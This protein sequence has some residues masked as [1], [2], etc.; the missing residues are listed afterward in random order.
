MT[1]VP[2]PQQGCLSHIR[3]LDLLGREVRE[4]WSG[5]LARGECLTVSWDGR[6]DERRL[7]HSGYYFL[8][9]RVGGEV[10]MARVVWLR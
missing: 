8:S 5:S 10:T 6:D 3:V 2:A 1:S 4:L 7:V 9:L